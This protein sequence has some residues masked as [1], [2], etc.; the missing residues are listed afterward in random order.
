MLLLLL[1]LLESLEPRLAFERLAM[2]P[3]LKARRCPLNM[4]R[5]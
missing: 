3:L 1:L 2:T 5:I 4:R